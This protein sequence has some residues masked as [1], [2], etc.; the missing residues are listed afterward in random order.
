MSNLLTILFI[1]LLYINLV[2]VAIIAVGFLQSQ[3][4]E[5]LFINESLE[6]ISVDTP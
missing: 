4:I 3:T 2:F 5:I 1:Y 6:Q